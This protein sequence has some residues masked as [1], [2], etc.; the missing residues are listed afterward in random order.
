MSE[1]RPALRICVGSCDCWASARMRTSLK[2]LPANQKRQDLDPPLKWT[3]WRNFD[4]W[5]DELFDVKFI[6]TMRFEAT[7]C[8]IRR[9]N[10]DYFEFWRY[11]IWTSISVGKYHLWF[12]KP[13][14]LGVL[15]SFSH[16]FFT[17]LVE[18]MCPKEWLLLR[19]SAAPWWL[20]SNCPHSLYHSA[21]SKWF[22]LSTCQCLDI[23]KAS[24]FS[25]VESG[26][27]GWALLILGTRLEIS[28]SGGNWFVQIG[29]FREKKRARKRSCRRDVACLSCLVY[30]LSTY[31]LLF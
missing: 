19:L 18:R 25:K 2:R 28:D 1:T 7:Y 8:N 4:V 26:A 12:G 13:S 6:L 27:N 21:W 9:W 31:Q 17:S 3:T 15:A 5:N 16:I 11:V 24:S 23:A 10:Y 22:D 29:F 14:P 20:W 30:D